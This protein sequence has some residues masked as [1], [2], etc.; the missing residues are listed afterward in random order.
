MT[1]TG[2]ITF[3]A[4]TDW[5]ADYVTAA[6]GA[7]GVRYYVRQPDANNYQYP[8]G[9]VP[10]AY[11]D[12]GIPTG[13]TA[14]ITLYLYRK[15]LLAGVFDAQLLTFFSTCPA[16]TYISLWQEVGTIDWDKKYP[17]SSPGGYANVGPSTIAGMN[18]HVQNLI[19][20]N[21]GGLGANNCNNVK[22]GPITCGNGQITAQYDSEYNKELGVMQGGPYD[23]YGTDSYYNVPAWGTKNKVSQNLVDEHMGLWYDAAAG[24]SHNAGGT[25][26][27]EMVVTE[28]CSGSY[29]TQ[30]DF[31]RYM[32]T[33]M[34]SNHGT[35]YLTHWVD[36]TTPQSQP[37][38]PESKW[39]NAPYKGVIQALN[40]I[41]SWYG[42]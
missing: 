25:L 8:T 28:S 16:M 13:A 17:A 39:G 23:W 9:Y 29:S 22:F 14:L 41:Q 32:A 15:Q 38:P 37:F 2:R 1:S 10:P 4:N 5:Y 21:R 19:N 24:A 33:W 27:P 11:S 26:T 12:C 6:P 18:T 30:P 34:N 7:H 31:F 42:N 35:M 3:G 40:D 36:A 20:A